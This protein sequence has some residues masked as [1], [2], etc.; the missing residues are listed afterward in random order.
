MS[1]SKLWAVA[2]ASAM[3]VAIGAGIGALAEV[4]PFGAPVVQLE[5]VEVVGNATAVQP[6]RLVVG[7]ERAGR[8]TL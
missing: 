1:I 5:R 3:T 2:A 8:D 6:A 7:E 4:E